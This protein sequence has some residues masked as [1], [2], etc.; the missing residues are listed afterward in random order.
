MLQPTAPR[1]D[2]KTLISSDQTNWNVS[3]LYSEPQTSIVISDVIEEKTMVPHFFLPPFAN[4]S[5]KTHS[6]EWQ[7]YVISQRAV[8]P[9]PG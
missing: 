3:N 9:L 8:I 4:L 1:W 2:G 6:F 5:A 7:R